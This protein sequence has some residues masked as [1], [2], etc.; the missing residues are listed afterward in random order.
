MDLDSEEDEEVAVELVV[1]EEQVD[2]LPPPDGG[3]LRPRV[4]KVRRPGL[5]SHFFR[6]LRA[7]PWL[8]SADRRPAPQLLFRLRRWQALANPQ[9]LRKIAGSMAFGRVPPHQHWEF[10][11]FLLYETPTLGRRH[12]RDRLP[13]PGPRCA[14][15]GQGKDGWMHI[16]GLERD[17]QTG[18]GAF[19]GE[20]CSAV[21][22]WTHGK[23]MWVDERWW[24]S[25]IFAPADGLAV[26][27]LARLIS[28]ISRMYRW[29]RYGGGTG[30]TDGSS[31]HFEFSDAGFRWAWDVEGDAAHLA[32][33]FR[34]SE[35][36]TQ[37]TSA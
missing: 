14:C 34:A 10:V 24:R 18:V 8:S 25:S 13:D 12:T 31:S 23:G 16:W 20:G 28:T 4:G 32:P 9:V 19:S 29:A 3:P 6:V 17:Q 7:T 2:E 35:S 33:E 22:R 37:S 21:K 1:V 36:S 26:K 15:C 11:N 27:K 30:S 5:Q